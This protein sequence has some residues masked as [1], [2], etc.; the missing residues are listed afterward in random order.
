MIV[1]RLLFDLIAFAIIIFVN[2]HHIG[3]GETS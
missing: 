3:N 2:L 1:L